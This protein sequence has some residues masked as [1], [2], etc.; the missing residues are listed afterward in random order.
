MAIKRYEVRVSVSNI[1]TYSLFIDEDQLGIQLA[2]EAVHASGDKRI[3]DADKV[4][5][6]SIEELREKR[7]VCPAA[8]GGGE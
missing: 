2:L 5:L 6:L 1:L 4:E 7:S 8:C 3:L